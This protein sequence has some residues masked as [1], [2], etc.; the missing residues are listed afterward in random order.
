MYFVA[1]FVGPTYTYM[2]IDALFRCRSFAKQCPHL[3]HLV[4]TTTRT[5]SSELLSIIV[6]YI[7]LFRSLSLLTSY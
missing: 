1:L 6:V 4:R 2:H 5:R 7:P 3:L